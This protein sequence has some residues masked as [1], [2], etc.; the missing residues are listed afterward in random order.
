MGLDI[1]L[2]KYN[3]FEETIRR[4]GLYNEFTDKLWSEFPDYDSL[5]TE[6]KNEIRDKSKEYA[7]SLGLDSYGE[8]ELGKTCISMPSEKYPEHL[9]KVGYFRSSYNGSGINKILDNL[10]LGGLSTIFGVDGDEYKV[11]PN[12][13][14]SLLRI[15]NTIISFKRK[16]NYR[17]STVDAN[18][19]RDTEI[20]SEK[21]ALEVFLEEIGR[22]STGGNGFDSYSNINGEF[23]LKEPLKVLAL[24]PGKSEF[25]GERPC[26]YV[27]TEGENEWYIQA[28][29]IIKET[30][31]WVL[32]QEDKEKYYLHWS[33]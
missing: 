10:D 26:T 19:F 33:G 20:K 15:D 12:W 17:V 16:G 4:E 31:E 18:I 32:K 21:R 29:Y 24:M 1:Y 25:F 23:Y 2:Y 27:V 28:L 5:T 14:D 11:K 9:F 13:E 8:D 22:H 30:I 6:Q 3:N 7:N